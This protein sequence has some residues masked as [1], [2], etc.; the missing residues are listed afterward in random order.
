MSKQASS[1]KKP[2]V[3][4]EDVL[5]YFFPHVIAEKADR[6]RNLSPLDEMYAYY[7]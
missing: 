4:T 5:G 3:Q 7:S 6:P 2:T 1:R